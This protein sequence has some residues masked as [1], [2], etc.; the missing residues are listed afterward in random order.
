MAAGV[1]PH[2]HHNPAILA[3]L[4]VTY[5]GIALGKIPGLKLNRTGIAL[6]LSLIHIS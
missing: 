3:V 4:V 1:S 5:V 6:L 2:L